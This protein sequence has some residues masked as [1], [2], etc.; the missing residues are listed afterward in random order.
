MDNPPMGKGRWCSLDDERALLIKEAEKQVLEIIRAGYTPCGIYAS[1][2]AYALILDSDHYSL[3]SG[4][5]G[6]RSPSELKML[7]HPFK[8]SAVSS[9]TSSTDLYILVCREEDLDQRDFVSLWG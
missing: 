2:M 8:P 5:D 1:P 4:T 9:V 7:G 6:V 3:F